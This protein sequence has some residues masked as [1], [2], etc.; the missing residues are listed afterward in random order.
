MAKAG[1]FVLGHLPLLTHLGDPEV[2]AV[3]V[4]HPLDALEL[5]VHHE[6][7]ALAAEEDGG[8]LHGHAVCGEALVLPGGHVGVV[9]Q[10]LQGVQ[11]GGDRDGNLMGG[12]AMRS[13]GKRARGAGG[14]T[15]RSSLT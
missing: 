13:E 6:R 1:P 8:V 9:G 4:L 7:P 11:A 2:F 10:H 3:F 12:N 5:R 14:G 15:R